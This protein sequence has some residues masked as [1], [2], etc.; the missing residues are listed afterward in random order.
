MPKSKEVMTATFIL[1][2]V[3]IISSFIS[4][5]VLLNEIHPSNKITGLAVLDTNIKEN[6]TE[7]VQELF[8][9]PEK[10]ALE[11][12]IIEVNDSLGLCN[13]TKSDEWITGNCSQSDERFILQLLVKNTGEKRISDL[14]ESFYCYDSDKT[15]FWSLFG[16][17]SEGTIYDQNLNEQPYV[18]IF[19]P[20]NSFIFK[21]NAERKDIKENQ[22]NCD[23]RF[24]SS[25]TPV[26]IKKR[27]FLN[28]TQIKEESIF[29]SKNYLNSIVNSVDRQDLKRLNYG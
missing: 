7:L 28:F 4:T 6:T 11:I 22:V 17:S 12:S 1:S 24:F 9:E 21:I 13:I 15:G 20:K 23:V 3:I 10:P 2:F 5:A 25:E 14:K 16:A 19:E 8:K 29:D 26:Q 18:A 27:I